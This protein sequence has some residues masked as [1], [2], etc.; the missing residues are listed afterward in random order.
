MRQPIRRS[1]PC[2]LIEKR[3]RLA[4]RLLLAPSILWFGLSGRC[5]ADDATR[6]FAK[7]LPPTQRVFFDNI[8]LSAREFFSAYM[9]QSAEERRYAELYLLGVLDA[10]EGLS[11]C[12]YRAFKT[13]TLGEEIY[14]GFRSLEKSEEDRRA[15]HVIAGILGKKFPCRGN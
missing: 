4:C 7:P 8:N 9:S 15:A 6:S 2:E 12:D 13:T 1:W 5:S 10:T 14:L 11:W 3:R